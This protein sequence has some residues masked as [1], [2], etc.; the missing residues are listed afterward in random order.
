MVK[1]I[2]KTRRQFADEL[3]LSIFVILALK[4]LTVVL[5]YMD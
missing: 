5:D 2:Q 4:G 3:F 1:H